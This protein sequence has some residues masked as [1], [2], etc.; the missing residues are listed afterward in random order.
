M[1]DLRDIW[2]NC[3]IGRDFSYCQMDVD[4]LMRRVPGLT[5]KEGEHIVK[6]GLTP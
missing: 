3:S 1:E 6:L 2:Y 5:R 4:E